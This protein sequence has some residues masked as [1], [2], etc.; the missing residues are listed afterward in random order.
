MENF[1]FSR[2]LNFLIIPIYE[3]VLNALCKEFL[4]ALF[5]AQS[6]LTRSHGGRLWWWW[7]WYFITQNTL[8]QGS[9]TP[10]VSLFDDLSLLFGH[11]PANVEEKLGEDADKPYTTRAI[12][13]VSDKKLKEMKTTRLPEG[14]Y[15]I[16]EDWVRIRNASTKE[17]NCAD[18]YTTVSRCA[19]S[20]RFRVEL[21]AKIKICY[22]CVPCC[23][24]SLGFIQIMPACIYNEIF[25]HILPGHYGR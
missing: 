4:L 9:S 8:S 7:W 24:T 23:I 5:P 22:V 12:S 21:L 2:C 20:R 17:T 1:I 19:W 10:N 18:M 25:I 16:W 14:R 15:G 13:I 6:L 3:T 11:E